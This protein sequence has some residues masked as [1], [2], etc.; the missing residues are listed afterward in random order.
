MSMVQDIRYG[1]RTL[2]KSP[3]FTAVA[4]LTLALGIGANTAIF[5]VANGLLLRSLPYPDADRLVLLSMSSAGQ[6][7]QAAVVSY[8]RFRSL[9]EH[10]PRSFSG[11]AA[12]VTE[13]FNISGNSEAEQLRAARVSW[14]FLDILGIRPAIGRTFTAAEDKSGG[15]QV[16]MISHACWLR[17]FGGAGNV[18][19]KSIALDSR[20]YSVIGVLPA[21]FAFAPAGENVDIWA[22]R[23]FE[24]NI[25]TPQQVYG[26]AGFLTIL[27]R[28]QGG[29]T[30]DQAQAEMDVVNRQYLH[31]NP[32]RPDA[33][34]RQKVAVE[35]LQEETVANVRPALLILMGAVGVVLLIACAN[36]ASLLLSRALGR[37]KEVA[38]RA[39]LGAGRGALLR[40]LAIESLL[41]ALVSGIA[42][43]L[44]S[45]WGTHGLA[46][47]TRSTV[48][49]I[50]SVHLDSRVLAFTAALS[51]LSGALFG[52]APALQL[53]KPDLNSVLRD[54]GRGSAGNRRRHRGRNLLV[55]SQV[56]LSTVLLVAAGLLIHS[57]V[58][59]ETASPGFEARNILTLTIALPPTKYGTKPQM[60]A[61]YNRML[62]GVR[63]LPGVESV[64]MSSALPVNVTRLSPMLPEGQPVVPMAQRPILNVQTISPE[65][66]RVLRIPLLR[67]RM[68][69]EH[70]DENSAAVCVVNQA[71]VRRFWPNENPTGKHIFLG[72]TMK[73]VEVVGVLGDVKNWSLASDANPEIFLPFPQLPWGWLYLD[74]RTAGDPHAL[75]AAVRR[76]IAAIDRDQPVTN[77]KSMDEVLESA[78]A[79]PRFTMLLLGIFSALAFTLAVVGIYGLVAYSVAQ[80][81]QELGVR[82]ALGATA[83]DITTLVLGQG[84]RLTGIGILVGLAVSL[85]LTRWM[86]SLLY[87]TSALDP[88]AF[89]LSAVVFASVATVASYLPARRAVRIDP[90]DA[91]RVE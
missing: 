29:V 87:K 71:T 38:I 85:A 66:A 60:I 67:G 64:A 73:S 62:S 81:T 30:V 27:A 3:G 42:G 10:Q 35:K 46:A 45:I 13:S 69:T 78:S 33:D 56:A 24:L 72:Q 86:A 34:P 1:A 65:Y 21:R 28:L 20:D 22:P 14:N 36:V 55:A 47:V 83:G 18:L 5:T 12:F 43:I 6:R 11:I 40:Q 54:E 50:A 58:R 61:F 75:T 77:V 4:V 37:R 53:S 16:V 91:L 32:G 41:L 9:I 8:L 51:L 15:R 25:A 23:V 19:G 31:D 44:L 90:T 88:V 74:V 89:G 63:T 17:L 80:R 79:Q 26:G 7:R 39:A 52:L 68:F 84:L 48:P 2:A 76:E 49:G 59:L 82:I 70:D 57:F